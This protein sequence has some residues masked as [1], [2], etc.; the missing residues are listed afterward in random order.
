MIAK[1]SKDILV[2]LQESSEK[3]T[4]SDFAC[5]LE[6]FLLKRYTKFVYTF[7]DRLYS[8]NGL[9]LLVGNACWEDTQFDFTA[10][11][12]GCYQYA[13]FKHFDIKECSIWS[14]Y[15]E[16]DRISLFIEYEAPDYLKAELIILA[17]DFPATAKVMLKN[18]DNKTNSIFYKSV[19]ILKF[20]SCNIR[21]HNCLKA[22]HL[23]LIGDLIQLTEEF[24][25][26]VPNLGVKC[27]RE[28]KK[29]LSEHDLYLNMSLCPSLKESIKTL[30]MEI[31]PQKR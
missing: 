18:E 20:L 5:T 14:S 25:I 24:L 2:E 12:E 16:N 21:I 22:E 11:K 7:K 29:S 13:A 8:E 3:V 19:G 26:N 6:E 31:A 10:I 27:L 23:Y 17:R 4:D 15:P 1:I 30:H 9:S 28:I